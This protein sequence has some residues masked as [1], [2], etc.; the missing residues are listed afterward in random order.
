MPVVVLD[1][2]VNRDTFDKDSF[3]LGKSDDN[4]GDVEG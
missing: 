4:L 2:T 3:V 1:I